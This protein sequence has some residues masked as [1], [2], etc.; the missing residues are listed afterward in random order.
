[1]RRIAWSFL[2]L[3]ALIALAVPSRS[4]A[5]SRDEI[6]KFRNRESAV[7][8]SVKNKELDA[9][10]KVFDKDYVAVYDYGIVSLP[11]ELNG[12]SK[13]TLRDYKLTDLKLRHLDGTNVL[14]AYKVTV[15]GDMDGQSMSGSYNALTLWRRSGNQWYVAA[16]SEVKAKP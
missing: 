5:Q 13:V 8:E 10:R 14:V 2:P 7:W 11:E 12:M 6:T 3:A 4:L 9:I 16:H 1:M 15:D